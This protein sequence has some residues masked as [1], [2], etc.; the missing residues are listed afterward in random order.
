MG[1]SQ[2][3]VGAT[4]EERRQAGARR[5]GEGWDGPLALRGPV[6]ADTAGGGVAG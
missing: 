3:A 6:S 1:S 5:D 4:S 2:G